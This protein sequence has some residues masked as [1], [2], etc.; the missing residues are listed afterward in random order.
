MK[1]PVIFVG[2][3]SPM[4]A[5]EDNEF[6][7][8][9][10][11]LG[12][13]IPKP[14]AILAVSAHWYTD[15]TK[16]SDVENP[17]QIYDMYGFPKALYELKYPVKGSKALADK[18]VQLVGAGSVIDN[19]WG[20]DHGTWSVLCRMFPEANIPVV[21]LS[22]NY[23]A[24]AL[25]HYQIGMAL[26]SLREEGVLILAS[27]NIVHNLGLVNW[28]MDDGYPEAKAFDDYIKT[29]ILSRN[30]DAAINYHETDLYTERAFSSPDHYFPL[31]YALGASS[32]EDTIEVFNDKC[33]MG[34]MSMTGYL[35]K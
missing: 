34:T 6:T 18:V 27:G 33:I 32:D 3:G 1:M 26:K 8:T 22:V 9:W 2:H 17:E 31:L 30:Y 29:N 23:R 7:K 15:G 11:A 16:T 5:I 28:N 4:N 24:P 13:K 35:F 14:K 20:I 25:V 21:Q 12:R 10:E 19:K